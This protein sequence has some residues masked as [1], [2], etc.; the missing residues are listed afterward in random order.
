MME[1]FKY[2]KLLTFNILL[3]LQVV[4]TERK[5][6]LIT[7]HSMTHSIRVV[8]VN[9]LTELYRASR[10]R[11]ALTCVKRICVAL[12]CA[13]RIC[14]TLTCANYPQYLP[15]IA[16]QLVEVTNSSL[17]IH[18]HLYVYGNTIC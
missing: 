11:V 4:L 1:S 10:K 2:L 14:A 12:A 15:V 5:I 7:Y 16:A 8:N 9:V 3:F 18:F 6:T 17:S 13:N